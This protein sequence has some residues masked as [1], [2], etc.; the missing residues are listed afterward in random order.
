MFFGWRR[1]LTSEVHEW[2]SWLFLAGAFGHIVANVRP[3]VNHLK[4]RWGK[5]SIAVSIVLLVTCVLPFGIRTGHQLRGAVEQAV[6]NAPLSTLASLAN[7][8]PEEVENRLKAHGVTGTL[9]Q[10]V[11]EA[12]RWRPAQRGTVARDRVHERVRRLPLGGKYLGTPIRSS[13]RAQLD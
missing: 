9:Q 1:G 3:F 13:V 4:S 6:L 11:H 10:S 5:I 8:A 7:V 12:L 2:F